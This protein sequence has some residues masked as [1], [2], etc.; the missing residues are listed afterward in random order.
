MLP[1]EV[2][3]IAPLF[4]RDHS[5]LKAKRVPTSTGRVPKSQSKTNKLQ[6]SLSS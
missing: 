5:V 4:T 6:Y 2:V 3:K 1:A